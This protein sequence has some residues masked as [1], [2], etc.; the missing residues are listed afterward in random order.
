MKPFWLAV[1]FAGI[2]CISMSKGETLY[3]TVT[4]T[5]TNVSGLDD[6]A[7]VG[8][9]FT[10]DETIHVTDATATSDPGFTTYVDTTGNSSTSFGDYSF[11]GTAPQ[12]IV[13]SQWPT[14]LGDKLYGYQFTQTGPDG[15][16]TVQLLSILPSVA[17]TTALTSI[18]DVSFS[19]FDVPPRPFIY[20]TD[21]GKIFAAGSATGFSVEIQTIPEPSALSLFVPGLAVLWW[22]RRRRAK[23]GC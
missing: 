16:S 4:G 19:D 5:L 10:F 2:G 8:A 22:T 3:I 21:S 12:A 6:S 1:F 18:Q 7:K 17:P 9:P 23:L 15:A 14:Q 13:Y 11:T 20:E